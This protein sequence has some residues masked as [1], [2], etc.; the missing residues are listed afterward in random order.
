MKPYTVAL[1]VHLVGVVGLFVGYGLEWTSSSLLRRAKTADQA[2]DWLGL[3]RLSLPLSGPGLLVLILSG[4]YLASMSG[5]M[6]QGWISAS[7]LGI[8]FA[9][10]IGFVFILP[11]TRA[12][13]L[14]LGESVGLLSAPIRALL[15]DPVLLTLVRVRLLLAL[16]IVYLMTVKTATFTGALGVLV[17]AAAAGVL[18]A[19]ASAYRPTA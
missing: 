10:G 4:S 19:L 18:C 9:L 12:L 13:R 17:V 16:G 14:A 3:Y 5:A 15:Q 7:L 11:R 8:L 1:F 6:R 2:R